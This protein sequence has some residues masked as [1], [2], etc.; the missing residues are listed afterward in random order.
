M[1]PFRSFALVW[2]NNSPKK[3]RTNVKVFFSAV[4]TWLLH[5]FFLFLENCFFKPGQN[6]NKFSKEHC[7]KI[8]I[9]F[10]NQRNLSNVFHF[11][12]RLPYGLVSCVV[13]EFQC[14]RCNASYYGET[15]RHLKV[16]S[17]EHISVSPINFYKS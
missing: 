9:V 12:D 2:R 11:K 6:F 1:R 13:Y 17:G 4:N 5:L 7:C 16:R 8:Q 15:D 10:K 14:G 3:G